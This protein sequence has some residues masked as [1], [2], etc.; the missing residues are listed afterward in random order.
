MEAP[1]GSFGSA[2]KKA[3]LEKKLTQEKL[4]ELISITTN[5]VK[6][7]ESGRRDPSMQ[8]LHK[9]VFALDFSLDSWYSNS[10]DEN[11]ELMNKINLCLGRCNV[12]ELMITYATVAALLSPDPNS[13][14][15][16]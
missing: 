5:H 12:H 3:R 14:K 6:Q 7:I 8:V 10:N 4:A 16:E 9:L 1:K 13:D 11:Q 15:T 2:I